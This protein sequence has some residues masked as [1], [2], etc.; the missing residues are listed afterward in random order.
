MTLPLLIVSHNFLPKQ[1]F[2][3]YY[4]NNKYKQLNRTMAELL[5][6]KKIISNPLANL[7]RAVRSKGR[8]V[9]E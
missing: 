5:E 6:G 4:E 9:Q 2:L 1:D 8:W 3:K 7:H